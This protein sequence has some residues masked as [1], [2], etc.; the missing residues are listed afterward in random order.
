MNL[1]L[2]DREADVLTSRLSA[3]FG[4]LRME[5]ADTDSEEWRNRLK[6]DEQTLL[7]ILG[8]LGV[9]VDQLNQPTPRL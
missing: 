6:A 7:S 5:I 2:T 9:T 4:D 8:K 3:A 1:E